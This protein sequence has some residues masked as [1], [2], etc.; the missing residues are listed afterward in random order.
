MGYEYKIIIAL[1]TEEREAVAQLILSKR[2]ANKLWDDF[3][4]IERDGI[5]VCK[6]LHP[7]V[8]KEFEELHHYLDTLKKTYTVEEL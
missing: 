4:E 3:V 8:W 6:N 7:D 2:T 1:T 5:Y